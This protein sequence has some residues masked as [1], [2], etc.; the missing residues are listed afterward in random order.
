M[1]LQLKEWLKD[2]NLYD[3]ESDQFAINKNAKKLH[4]RTQ[5]ENN[6]ITNQTSLD[7]GQK[8]V[9]KNNISETKHIIS[10]TFKPKESSDGIVDLFSSKF[11]KWL[12]EN[13]KY[14]F[15]TKKCSYHRPSALRPSLREMISV[16]HKNNLSQQY[17]MFDAYISMKDN[18]EI[19]FGCCYDLIWKDDEINLLHLGRITTS[20]FLFLNFIKEFNKFFHLENSGQVCICIKNSDDLTLHGF[21]GSIDDGMKWAEPNSS[22]WTG[23]P[24]PISDLHNIRVMENF[25]PEKITDL[26]FDLSR[27]IANAFGLSFPLCYNHDKTFP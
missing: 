7:E 26:T 8:I 10:F 17:G 15:H 20:I 16:Y 18:A 12:N 19:E 4:D 14:I 9:N 25:E 24:L 27:H 23:S 1:D 5:F 6:E 21:G 2:R 3:L 13:K 11:E 22:S